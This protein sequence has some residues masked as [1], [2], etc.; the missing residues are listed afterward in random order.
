M[1]TLF[2]QTTVTWDTIW[3][4]TQDVFVRLGSAGLQLLLAVLIVLVGW[5]VARLVSGLLRSILI[6][7]GFDDATRR[8]FGPDAAGK[9]LDPST[10]VSWAVRS[11]IL[12]LAIVVAGDVLGF[13]LSTSVGDRLQTVLPRVVSATVE[14]LVGITLAMILGTLTHRLFASAGVRGARWRGQAVTVGLSAF[15]VQLALEQLG[16]A[17][18]LIVALGIAAMATLG[19]AVGLAFGLGCR[20]L[21]RDFVVE[22]LRSLDE[23]PRQRRP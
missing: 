4:R 13:D 6:R 23:E 21:A 9:G 1:G 20:D 19:I 16:L 8:L 11:A 5:L 12:V 7:T 17:A 18:Q 10:M 3:G 2:L 14:L 22:Y 15:A